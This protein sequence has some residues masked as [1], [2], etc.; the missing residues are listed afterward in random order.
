M[1][2]TSYRAVR[3]PAS[4]PPAAPNPIRRPWMKVIAVKLH[5]FPSR[6]RMSTSTPPQTEAELLEEATITG[7]RD[8]FAQVNGSINIV[9]VTS[10]AEARAEVGA[11]DLVVYFSRDFASGLIAPFARSMRGRTSGD[12]RAF[13]SNV[14]SSYESDSNAHNIGLT[15][16]NYDP[17]WALTEIYVQRVFSHNPEVNNLGNTSWESAV[18]AVG[19][20][21]AGIAFH[22]GMHNKVEPNH[23]AVG[24][25]EFDL[26][27]HGGHGIADI[28]GYRHDPNRENVSLMT[29]FIR[30][31]AYPQQVPAS[32]SGVELP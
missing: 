26:H 12:M 16:I 9:W 22:E 28:N 7:L 13:Y 24:D 11:R 6:G 18:R 25:E 30:N 2:I 10:V 27:R 23:D 15:L 14:L 1:T 21:L 20:E 29:R 31:P 8:L 17:R 5:D 4:G 32:G 19:R 3:A